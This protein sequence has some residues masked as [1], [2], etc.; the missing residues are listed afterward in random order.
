[1]TLQRNVLALSIALSAFAL[2]G[3]VSQSPEPEPTETTVEAIG[4]PNEK[5][6]QYPQGS[7]IPE[8]IEENGVV[9]EGLK[10]DKNGNMVAESVTL[11]GSGDTVSV[12]DSFKEVNEDGSFIP[13]KPVTQDHI[14]SAVS[15]SNAF[16][17]LIESKDWKGLCGLLEKPGDLE[18]C[19]MRLQEGYQ[20]GRDWIPYTP[21]NIEIYVHQNDDMTVALKEP[22]DEKIQLTVFVL[23]DGEWKIR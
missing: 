17:K 20:Q 7:E 13:S 21:E 2:S 19:Q 23:V 14:E 8:H 5:M 12:L 10:Y 16:Q 4:E 11:T 22:K 6:E 18:Q 3:C 9:V 1:M 15:V